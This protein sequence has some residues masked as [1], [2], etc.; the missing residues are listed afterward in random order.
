MHHFYGGTGLGLSIVKK[1][2]ELQGGEIRATSQEGQG[3]VIEFSLVLPPAAAPIQDTQA[4]RP[5][6]PFA[7]QHIRQVLVGEDDL[8]SQ[9]VLGQLLKRWGLAATVVGNGH[10]VIEAL[11]RQPYDLLILDYHMP[12][13]TGKEVV[14]AL[15]EGSTIPIIMLSGELLQPD[16]LPSEEAITMLKKPVEPVVLQQEIARLDQREEQAA[17]NLDYLREITGNNPSLMADLVDTFIQQVP[18]EIDK[19]KIAL[20]KKDWAALY[21]AVHKSKPNFKY[22]GVQAVQGLLDQFEQAV[23]QQTNQTSYQTYI[24]EIEAFTNRTIPVL[25]AAKK[26]LKRVD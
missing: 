2:V 19:M 6:E 5:S 12:G 26:K 21:M 20:Q 9:K 22:V 3:T 18:R 15:P 25:E 14:Q 23:Q 7:F 24:Q 4:R 8:M 10:Q 16:Q 17:I 13:L 11:E 1:I